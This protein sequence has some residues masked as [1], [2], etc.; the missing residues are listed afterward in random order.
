METE[1]RR[2]FRAR[3]LRERRQRVVLLGLLLG[4]GLLAY[5]LTLIAGDRQVAPQTQ[6]RSGLSLAAPVQQA[7]DD[8][9]RSQRAYPADNAAAGLP[10]PRRF[11]DQ[12]VESVAID[13]GLVVI[14]FGASAHV[15]LRARQLT[16]IPDVRSDG[17]LTWGCDAPELD[18]RDLPAQCARAPGAA[19]GRITTLRDTR[20]SV[21]LRSN[22]LFGRNSDAHESAHRCKSSSCR[23]PH[24]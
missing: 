18:R 13:Q 8:Y 23:S 20:L 14:S 10:A 6:V 16:L 22:R 5:G 21:M 15:R 2:E 7:I 12:H 17:S 3:R 9:V 4:T 1:T 11:S 24:Q 19:V